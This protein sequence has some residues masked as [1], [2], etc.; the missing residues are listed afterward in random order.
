M[1]RY[2]DKDLFLSSGSKV[3]ACSKIIHYRELLLEQ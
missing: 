1:D 2:L 3:E